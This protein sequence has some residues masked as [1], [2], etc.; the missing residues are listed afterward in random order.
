LT[1]NYPNVWKDFYPSKASC[2]YKSGP[3]W[4]VHEGPEEQGIHCEPSTVCCPDIVPVWSAML[5]NIMKCLDDLG[6]IQT[7]VNPF[8]WAN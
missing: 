4:E 5:K 1:K 7:C 6:V 8:A 3:A 2:I